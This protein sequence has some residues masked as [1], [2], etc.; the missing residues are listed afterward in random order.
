MISYSLVQALSR[1]RLADL[2]DQ[3]RRNSLARTVRN[4]RRARQHH[5]APRV[6]SLVAALS[7]WGHR[8]ALPGQLA[9]EAGRPADRRAAGYLR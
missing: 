3:A 8:P 2:H 7:R 9:R 4:A 6:P 5:A 1:E